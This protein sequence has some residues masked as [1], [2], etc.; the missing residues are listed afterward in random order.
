M[1]SVQQQLATRRFGLSAEALNVAFAGNTGT[2]GGWGGEP[3][4]PNHASLPSP[5][6]GERGGICTAGLAWQ[7][8]SGQLR[9]WQGSRMRRVRG[10]TLT[11]G[12]SRL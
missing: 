4:W 3:S 1:S 10:S 11:Y 7:A 12:S 8:P 2:A 5:Q 6:S 9:W